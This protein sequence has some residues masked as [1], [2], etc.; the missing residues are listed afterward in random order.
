M[1]NKYIATIISLFLPG[2]GEIIQGGP[3]TRNI[4]L[5]LVAMA[6]GAV[7]AYF[8]IQNNFTINTVIIILSLINFIISIFSAYETYKMSE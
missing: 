1:I 7:T 4:I 3:V 5:Y 6:T 2:I 8:R